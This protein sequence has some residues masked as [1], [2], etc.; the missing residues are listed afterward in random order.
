MRTREELPDLLHA[1]S[2]LVLDEVGDWPRW[3]GPFLD[4]ATRLQA[5]FTNATPATDGRLPFAPLLTALERALRGDSESSLAIL[6][7]ARNEL[8]GTL[9][10]SEPLATTFTDDNLV[11]VRAHRRAAVLASFFASCGGAHDALRLF[12]PLAAAG[13]RATL[14]ETMLVARCLLAIEDFPNAFDVAST[15][16]QELLDRRKQLDK[17]SLRLNFGGRIGPALVEI[18]VTSVLRGEP[19]DERLRH[20]LF[21]LD[22]HAIRCSPRSCTPPG[23]HRRQFFSGSPSSVRAGRPRPKRSNGGRSAPVC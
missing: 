13:R 9:D 23:R 19:D 8:I 5:R 11:R 21:V 14:W 18:V 15:G 10:L 22:L 4:T 7:Q 6:R 3:N 20:A 17:G 2:K 1:Y 12:A 16:L